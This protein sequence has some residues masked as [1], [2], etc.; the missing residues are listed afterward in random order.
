MTAPIIIYRPLLF[1]QP[2]DEVGA[3]DGAAVDVSCDMASV[4]LSPDT[5]TIDVSNFCG[6]YSLP[7][8]VTVGA[9]FEV[10]INADTH[11]NWDALVGVTCRAELFDRTSDNVTG[12]KFRTFTTVVPIN[13]ALYGPTTP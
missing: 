2:L 3:D 4:E 5:P 12:G 8:E 11:A 9:T 6:N 1:L 7:G 13:P 10:I